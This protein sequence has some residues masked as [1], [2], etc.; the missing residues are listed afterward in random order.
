MNSKKVVFLFWSTL[1][2]GSVSGGIV[3]F[4]INLEVY[5]GDGI[6]NLIVG[7]IYMLGISAAFSLVAQMGFFAYLFLHRF[8]LGLSKSHTLWNRIQ[9]VLIVFVFFDLVYFRYIAF[10]KEHSFW[11]IWSSRHCYLFMRL[12]WHGLKQKKQIKAHL[13]P[14]FSLCLSLRQSSGCQL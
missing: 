13:S 11:G 1:L 2:F 14:R 12:L 8:G 10:G 3:G 7:I 6:G 4:F 9:W 5:L